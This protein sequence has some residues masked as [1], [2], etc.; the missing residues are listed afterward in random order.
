MSAPR[1]VGHL[2]FVIPQCFTGGHGGLELGAEVDASLTP[3]RALAAA[4]AAAGGQAAAARAVRRAGLELAMKPPDLVAIER[5]LRRLKKGE[6]RCPSDD[7]YLP[8]ICRALGKSPLDL[9][10]VSDAR[11]ADDHAAGFTAISHKFIPVFVGAEATS[12]LAQ[13]DRFR[14]SSC[15]WMSTRVIEL[16]T[17]DDSSCTATMF[18]F[19]V[20]V[21]HISEERRFDSIAELALWR[22]TT[23]AATRQWVSDQVAA[24]WPQITE[25]PQYVLSMYWLAEHFW[26]P[27]SLT[28]AMK[29]LCVPSVLLERSTDQCRDTLL[30]GAEVAERSR[31]RDGFDHPDVTPFGVDG[32]SIGHASWSGVAYYAL[33]PARALTMDELV[34]FETL[35]QA[36][37]CY[38][39]TI[40]RAVQ[41]GYDPQMPDSYSWRFLRAVH[42][43]LTTA[44]PRETNQVRLMRDAILATS[45]LTRQLVDAQ[46]MLH[47]TTLV[48]R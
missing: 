39:D 20:V 36:L 8:A 37:W 17:V 32:V 28:T 6:T 25:R 11:Q 26:S 13:A 12:V 47:D 27:D 38:T 14:G 23:H 18:D 5:T 2:P 48:E 44:Q 22:R 43:R 19:G 21:Y 42:S 10:G 15:E 41:N 16:S 1:G 3:N 45:R 29:L 4:I 24:R 9:F 40:F 34:S 7:F 35:V 31:L 30:P 33:S 46:T